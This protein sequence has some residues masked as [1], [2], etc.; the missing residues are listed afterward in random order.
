MAGIVKARAWCNN[1]VAY[2]AWDLD[3]RIDG[4]LGFMVVRVHEDTGERRLL[5]A[6]VAFAGQ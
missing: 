5:P 6:W 3:G 1:E 2:L 4:L